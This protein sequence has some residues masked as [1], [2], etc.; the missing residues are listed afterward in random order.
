MENN[1][2]N[3]GDSQGCAGDLVGKGCGI[4]AFAIIGVLL[5]MFL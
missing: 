5:I 1:F 4:L 3:G 2:N